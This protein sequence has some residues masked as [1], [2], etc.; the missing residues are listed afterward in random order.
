VQIPLVSYA[1]A[2]TQHQ[3]A[4]LGTRAYNLVVN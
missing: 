2:R 4:K 1:T 3:F